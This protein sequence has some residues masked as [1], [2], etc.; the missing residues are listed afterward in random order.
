[1]TLPT[2]ESAAVGVAPSSTIKGAAVCNNAAIESE[3]PNP[4]LR[5][6]ADQP[7]RLPPFKH[8]RAE[9][10][11]P[12]FEVAMKDH[13]SDLEAIASSSADGFDSIL[14]AY[15]RA[16]DLLGKVDAV[17][18]NYVSSL[19]T[20]EMQAVQ[21]T[22][23]PILSRHNS[24]TYDIPGLFVKIEK[25]YAMKDDMLEKGEWT[26]E[27]ARLAERVYI[28]FVR[29]GAKFD[30]ATKGEYADIQGESSIF[31]VVL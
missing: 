31:C 30:A 16:G 10:F 21:T 13:L 17:F 24:K 15:D 14:G 5:S 2:I 4:L 9:H 6:W 26:A 29:M 3:N 28:D 11:Q 19:N 27:Q 12:A 8:I 20:P 25:M 23:A 22:M 1:M 7:F 18:D